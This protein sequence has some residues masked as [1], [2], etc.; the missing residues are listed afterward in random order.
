MFQDIKA[1]FTD[2]AAF[3]KSVVLAIGVGGVV[4][5]TNADAINKAFP[6]HEG[7]LSLICG[8]AVALAGIQAHNSGETK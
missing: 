7:I 5:A 6:G 2:S 8:V 3:R 1:F 4:A